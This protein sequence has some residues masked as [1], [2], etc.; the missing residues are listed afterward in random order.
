MIRGFYSARSGLIY[1]QEHLNTIA[2]NIA[3]VSTVG[4]K[5]MRTSFKDLI[6]QNIN[7]P[8]AESAANVGHG[9]KINKNDLL[10]RGASLVPTGRELD[11]AIIEENGFFA[12]QTP[13]GETLYA[14]SG[15]FSLSNAD[16]T[17]YLINGSGHRVLNVDGDEIEIEFDDDGQYVLDP[18]E[19]GVFRF[20]N[21]YGLWATE[22]THFAETPESGA[23]ELI[24]TPTL[25]QNYL[26]GSGV[27]I[28][29][30]MTQMI[31]ASRAFGF[32]ARMLQT[33]D[34]VEQT[35]N[36]LRQ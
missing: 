28:A 12:V 4:F 25:R 19:I 5:A 15:N 1:H 26:E 7:R 32:S 13:A 22:G 34:E 17:Y 18:E 2:N 11:F 33:S 31:E 24:E 16:D 30:E 36:S 8:E 21:P 9:V 27:E 10:M 29:N 35:V 3:N 6:Y 20:P 14:R 23:A